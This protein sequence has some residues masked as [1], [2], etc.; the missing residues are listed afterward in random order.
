MFF[1]DCTFLPLTADTQLSWTKYGELFL[2]V[3]VFKH[4]YVGY[5]KVTNMIV[6]RYASKELLH[7]IEVYSEFRVLNRSYCIH[8]LIHSPRI[9]MVA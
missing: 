5:Q 7:I 9:K 8:D 4:N 3:Y 1:V 6:H 2:L